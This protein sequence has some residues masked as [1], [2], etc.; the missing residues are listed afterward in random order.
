MVLCEV[1]DYMLVICV[2]YF[3]LNVNE[4]GTIVHVNDLRGRSSKVA[5]NRNKK[6]RRYNSGIFS[7]RN[8]SKSGFV[9]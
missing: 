7:R 5:A 9:V 6:Y 1:Y 3:L 2:F 8:L 4:R